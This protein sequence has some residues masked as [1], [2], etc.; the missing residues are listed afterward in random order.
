MVGETEILMFTMKNRVMDKPY[1]CAMEIGQ[2]E[3]IAQFW[4]VNFGRAVSLEFDSRDRIAMYLKRNPYMSTVALLDDEI[5][6]TVLC[7]HDGRRGTLYHVAVSKEHRHKGIAKEMVE[8]SLT[9]LKQEGIDTAVLFAHLENEN[10]IE[11][12]KKSGWPSFP[13]VMYHCKET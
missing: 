4:K 12:W 8:R 13:N 9:C 3:K 11:Y 2:Y 5:I 1:V 7:G 10:A 6:G